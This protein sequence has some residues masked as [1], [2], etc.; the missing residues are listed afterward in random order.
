MTWGGLQVLY[1]R[2]IGWLVVM[3]L[4]FSGPRDLLVLNVYSGSCISPEIASLYLSAG[5][6][7]HVEGHMMGTLRH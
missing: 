5:V 7:L 6:V 1:A 3:Q 4:S 2:D